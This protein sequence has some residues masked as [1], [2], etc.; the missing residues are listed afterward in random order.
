MAAAENLAV[1]CSKISEEKQSKKK[2]LSK[3]KMKKRTG[4]KK[5]TYVQRNKQC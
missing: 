2:K 1:D 3:I 5:P 4:E